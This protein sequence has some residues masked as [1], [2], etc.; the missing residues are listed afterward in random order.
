MPR[1]SELV[2]PA[3]R[4]RAEESD[5][6]LL[7][8]AWGL[9][10]SGSPG[11]RRALLA[12]SESPAPGLRAFGVL[13]LAVLGDRRNAPVIVRALSATDAGTLPRAAA[14]FA[15][16]QLGLSQQASE[17][18]ELVNAPDPLL[19]SSALVALARLS[20]PTAPDAI[21]Q[22]LLSAEPEA[23]PGARAAALVFATGSYRRAGANLKGSLPC[24]ESLT[25]PESG[26]VFRHTAQRFQPPGLGA[27]GPSRY[28][29]GR[30]HVVIESFHRA[31]PKTFSVVP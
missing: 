1:L 15:V 8:A 3:G 28:F 18:L 30:H 11:A 16:G 21:A 7:A 17:L 5:P 25:P 19:S 27:P 29:G 13:G 20:A 4:S 2:A 9:S 23:R 12:L 14:A 22:Q 31:C 6:V 24:V 10:R 26:L